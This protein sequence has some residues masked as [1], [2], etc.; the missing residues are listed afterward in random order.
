MSGSPSA[1]PG[2]ASQHV[3]LLKE[4]TELK[5]FGESLK[6][7]V[8][9]TPLIEVISRVLDLPS[10]LNELDEKQIHEIARRVEDCKRTLDS[11]GYSYIR[12]IITRPQQ[13]DVFQI[14]NQADLFAKELRKSVGKKITMED[15]TEVVMTEALCKALTR[16]KFSIGTPPITPKGIEAIEQM[17]FG[18]NLNNIYQFRDLL[19][20][21]N[22]VKYIFDGFIGNVDRMVNQ[23]THYTTAD[24]KR[25]YA[26]KAVD[27][28]NF[29]GLR[30]LKKSVVSGNAKTAIRLI[31]EELFSRHADGSRP[32]KIM[33]EM[34]CLNDELIKE[35]KE[36]KETV[37][38]VRVSQ[39]PHHL[40]TSDKLEDKWHGILGRLI[41]VQDS[42]N[43]RNASNTIVYSLIPD[44]TQTLDVIHVKDSGTPANTQMNLRSIIENFSNEGLSVLEDKVQTKIAEYEDRGAHQFTADEVRLQEWKLTAQK[45]YISLKKF[46]DFIKFIKEIQS[47]DDAKLKQIQDGLIA[48]NEK[49]AMDYFFKDLKGK[50]YNIVSVPQG[51]GR[52]E[53]G[54]IGK[55]FSGKFEQRLAGFNKEACR[56]RLQA[57]KA[58]KGVRHTE[59]EAFSLQTAQLQNRT[60]AAS[61]RAVNDLSPI[62]KLSGNNAVAMLK[63]K[64]R[65]A[66]IRGV[67]GAGEKLEQ[68]EDA[69]EEAT[70]TNLTG[71]LRAGIS[72]RLSGLGIGSLAKQMERGA[73]KQ[74]GQLLRDGLG[75]VRSTFGEGIDGMDAV[76]NSLEGQANFSDLT[77]AEKLLNDIEKGSLKPNLALSEVGWT[78]DDVL[79]EDDFPASNYLKISLGKDG[80]LDADSLEEKLEYIQSNLRDFPELFQLFCA[81]TILIINDPHNP[82][83]RVM[84]NDTKVKLLRI[85]AK[86]HLTILSDDAYHKQVS[87]EVK[88]LQTDMSLTE[89]Y[90]KHKSHL[91]GPVTIYSSLPTTKWAMGAGERTGVVLSN[92][93]ETVNGQTFTE[94]VRT[95]TDSVN[96][97]SLRMDAEKYDIGLKAKSACKNLEPSIAAF[98]AAAKINAPTIPT[99]A[100][101]HPASI[102]DG[103]F[104]SDFADP[105]AKEFCGPLYFTL[106][107]ARNELD[108]LSIRDAD[109]MEIARFASDLVSKIKFDFRL[110]K[111]TQKDSAERSKV[112]AAAIDRVAEDFPFLKDSSIKP[113]GP[114]YACVKLDGGPSDPAL[115]PFLKAIAKARNIAAVPTKKGY[116]RFSFGSELDGTID[117]YNTLGIAVETDLRIL[118]E[119]WEKYKTER[120]RLNKAKDS[121]P[122]L[123]ALENIFPG[124]EIEMART[125]KEKQA[126]TSR[127]LEYKGK[128]RGQLV[129][130]RPANVADKMTGIEPDSA[131]S[132][133]TLT[134]IKCETLPEFLKSRQFKDVFNYY[135]LKIK[136]KVPALQHLEDTDVIAFFG[137]RQFAEKEKSRM[138]KDTEREIFEQIAIQIAK[139]WFSDRTV[140][141]LASTEDDSSKKALHGAEKMLGDHIRAFLDAFVT[142]PGAQQKLLQSFRVVAPAVEEYLPVETAYPASLQAGYKAVRGVKADSSLPAWNQRLISNG[143]FI[144]NAT[145]TDRSPVLSTPGTARVPGV[146]RAILRRDGDGKNAPEK[147]FFQERLEKFAEV[148]NPKDYIMKMVQ[149]GGTKVLLVMNRSYSHYMVE[150]LRLFPQTDLTPAEMANCKPD[151]VS[152][153]G[154]PTKVMGED[155]RIGYFMD[156]DNNGATIPVS[157]VDAESITDYMGYLKKP[158]L[159]VANEKVRE[160]EM[161]PVHGSAFSIIFKNGLRKTMV[162][163]GDS[164]TGKSETIIAMIEQI[165]TNQGLASQ[166]EGIEFLSGDMLSMF[167]GNDEQMYMLGTEQGDFMR[168][169][170]IPE[171]WKKRVRDR[172]NGG[173]KTNLND[174]KNPR[175]TIGNLCNPTEFQKP[176]RVNG[177]FNINNFKVPAG[178][179]VHESESTFNLIMNEYVKGYRGEKGTSGDQP[180][181]FASIEETNLPDKNAVLNE[182]GKELDLLLGWDVLTGPDGKAQNA[183]IKFNDI[184]GGVHKSKAMVDKLFVG[185]EIP[186]DREVVSI[187]EEKNGVKITYK[188][189][190]QESHIN[191][192][193]DLLFTGSKEEK[194]EGKVI[195]TFVDKE[196]KELKQEISTRKTVSISETTYDVRE[197]HFYATV[198][199]KDGKEEKV[200]VDREG[201]FSRIYSPIASTYAGNPFVGAENMG[202]VLERFAGVMERAGV[203]TGTLYTQLKVANMENDG[204]A[205]AS[206]DLLKFILEDERINARFQAHIR[207]VDGSL[208]EKYG[209]EVLNSSTIPDDVMA[210][211]LFLLERHGSDN[212]YPIDTKKQRINLETPH[213]KYDPNG[214]KKDFSPSL[215]TP[216]ITEAIADVCENEDY[217]KFNL[218]SFTF[219]M[220]EYKSIQAW[221]SKEELVYQVL[222]KNGLAKLN[223]TDTNISQIP[224]KEVKKAEKIA[225][226]I[227]SGQSRLNN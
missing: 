111:Q 47:A 220:D 170:D 30:G 36:D 84:K 94:F 105:A 163:A 3:D 153:L 203:I 9:I 171:D 172:I 131:T 192:S 156:E 110:D 135:L 35:M 71:M 166:L 141:I 114:F 27:F 133:I 73:P 109:N 202:P 162:M 132:I 76:L 26:K 40:L 80:E 22:S 216:E 215:I 197:N 53:I 13:S 209:A 196:G 70:A 12:R 138:F 147:R 10:N 160:K 201:V 217:N 222:M 221:D 86:Y 24:E 207:S 117:D 21:G 46:K 108:R 61:L 44:I 183:F 188:N 29:E 56:A 146:D 194:S 75:L 54:H 41:L 206:Q 168:M 139:I 137:A 218:K 2:E 68:L 142:T 145:A 115:K 81:S 227:I 204:P 104:A 48:K 181:F 51:G 130:D 143:E 96:T 223:Y 106:I 165:I 214:E 6:E 212:I 208:R 23:S 15:G 148:M 58:K 45:D 33:P 17:M 175:I 179:S 129:F 98:F 225:E 164:G 91:P 211:N 34:D 100:S 195:F 184:Q 185:K 8:I 226:A 20:G 103:I 72:K 7:E 180:N 186:M 219:S 99:S 87:K 191:P 101:I 120:A 1:R 190:D 88:D 92:D 198:H 89:F 150:E 177:F 42:Q 121:N 107:E 118:I 74:L 123:T 69:L 113:E 49:F 127:M 199:D 144:A 77:L 62:D 67:N 93:K 161:M 157:W 200:I 78:F 37:F 128:K 178:S 64:L 43:S 159:T 122:E 169:T 149:I 83:S 90:E 60:P 102:I 126:L 19:G 210:Y 14:V 28:N 193:G 97:M 140:K 11:F 82:T 59:T 116:V 112:V 63:E 52:K 79:D 173:S 65:A 55:F 182:F 152:F 32:V 50:D 134:E 189:G 158:V 66:G 38:V 174:K 224:P 5:K 155:Y 95:N 167:E 124:G 154:L 16:F 39:V 151:A 85:A 187:S 176:V 18:G 57:L 4:I 25:D 205:K 31:K 136:S 125:I 213:Y 119:Y